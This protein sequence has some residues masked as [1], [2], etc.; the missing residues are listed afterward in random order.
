MATSGPSIAHAAG[1]IPSNSNVAA[2]SRACQ[3]SYAICI[4]NNVSS[5][6]PYAFEVR[7]AISTGRLSLSCTRSDNTC[8]ETPSPLASSEIGSLSGNKHSSL[9]TSPG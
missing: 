3:K 5:E 2:N 7:I 9:T 6:D 4:P 1:T 8:A